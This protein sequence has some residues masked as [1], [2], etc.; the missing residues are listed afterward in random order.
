M[1]TRQAAGEGE[2]RKEIGL[3]K[4]LRRAV[5]VFLVVKTMMGL[6]NVVFPKPVVEPVT[7][8]HALETLY[9]LET[10]TFSVL[11]RDNISFLLRPP[12]CP[13]NTHILLMALSAPGNKAKR[14]QLRAGLGS[15]AGLQVIFLLG[16]P[17]SEAVQGEL[18]AEQ[19]AHRDIVQISVKDH[20][21][22][23][24]YKTLTGF[25]WGNRFCGSAKFIVKVDDDVTV[26]LGRLEKILADKYGV[27]GPAPDMVECPSVMRNMR[28]W[29]Q[30]HTA[31]IMSKWSISKADMSRRVYPDFCP[32]WLYV[33]SPRVGLALA[34]VSVL[35]A[36]QLMPKARLDDIF[37]TGFLRERLPWARLQQLHPGPA[38]TAWNSFF[39]HCPFLGITKNIFFNGLVLDK[40]SNGVSYIKG[41]KFYWCAFLEFFIL[42]NLEYMFPSLEE[43]TQPLWAVCQR[44]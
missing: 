17:G 19:F 44:S 41:Q 35:R 24:A 8:S 10:E 22:A 16:R 37:V 32:G 5:M 40:G 9:N 1:E 14:E 13:P 12:T 2:E 31:S 3:V 29:R 18:Q 21:T 33:V 20:Y 7:V 26:D 28:P 34:E 38:G 39:S 4:H 6:Q 11:D 25:V 36:H 42:E 43:H 23:L 15:Q 27:A 30:N